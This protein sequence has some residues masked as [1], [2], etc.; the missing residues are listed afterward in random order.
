MSHSDVCEFGWMSH[1]DLQ[2]IA[3]TANVCSLA[4]DGFSVLFSN[5]CD[6]T[7]LYSIDFSIACDLLKT[8][9]LL[10]PSQQVTITLLS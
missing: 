6:V 10:S 5:I 8:Y 4:S 2:Y 1:S 7:G 9:S 3:G